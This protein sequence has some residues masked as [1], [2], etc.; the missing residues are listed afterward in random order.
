MKL[1]A[2]FLSLLVLSSGACALEPTAGVKATV[3]MKTS[4]SWN[5]RPLSYPEGQAEA[6][7][8]IIEVAPGAETGWHLHT[9]PS[10]AVMLE[11]EL[12]VSTADGQV[13]RLKAGDA[14]AEVV[15][16][17][18]NG[19]NIGLIP[20]KLVVFYAGA[21]GKPLSVMAR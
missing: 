6:T 13:N 17:L 18:H 9:V 2:F 11:G 7:A 3:L 21:V 4:S 15:D 19:K 20:V 1:R 5:G 16:T 10:F 14:V 8:M 12:Q